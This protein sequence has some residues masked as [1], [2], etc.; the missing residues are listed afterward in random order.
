MQK[1]LIITC[2]KYDDGTEY[3]FYFSKAI[4]GEAKNRNIKIKEISDKEVEMVN[5]S[6]VVTKLD[7]NLIVLNGHGSADTIYGHKDCVLI[8]V[9][10][11]EQLLNGRITYA[12][13]CDAGQ[14]LGEK[15]VEYSKEGCFIGY[16]LPFIFAMDTRWT[17]NP[18]NDN[19]AKLFLEPSN[20]I[21][22]SL[23]KGQSAQDAYENSKKLILKNLRKVINTKEEDSFV[24]AEALWNNYFG[25]VILGNSEAKI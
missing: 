25:Q 20:S 12:R 16:S 19:K 17:A 7:Y 23:I 13:S 9:G 21:P 18:H 3:L 4:I 5:F 8:Q 6:K 11:N 1:G 10:K 15:C 24:L 2:P 22:I 14:M